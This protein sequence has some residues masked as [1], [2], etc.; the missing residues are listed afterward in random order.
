MSRFYGN[1]RDWLCLD[2]TAGWVRL[3]R[4][5]CFSVTNHKLSD[6]LEGEKSIPEIMCTG[7]KAFKSRELQERAVLNHWFTTFASN[8]I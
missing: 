2:M 5:G 6:G 7:M 1:R 8:S 3:H 4:T